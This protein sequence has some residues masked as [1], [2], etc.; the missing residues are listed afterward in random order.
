[1]NSYEINK[2]LLKTAFACMA[3]DG[4]IDKREIDIVYKIA[5][6][7]NLLILSEL[8]TELNALI[9]ELNQDSNKFITNYFND[10]SKIELSE[11]N[12]L[13]ILH[14]AITTIRAD[15]IMNYHEI[16]FFKTIRRYL[17]ISD[18]Q[19]L[20][21]YPDLDEL[22]E[23][24][25]VYNNFEDQI[26]SLLLNSKDNVQFSKIDLLLTTKINDN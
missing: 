13:L 22:L 15:E 12:Q 16:K 3:C 5:Q 24:D 9:D 21:N 17:S 7:E 2:L 26:K 14:N 6:E 4:S 19:I 10:L 18:D 1:M 8:Q 25:I 11:Q 20:N 23:Q